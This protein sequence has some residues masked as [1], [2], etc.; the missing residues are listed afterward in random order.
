MTHLMSS[1]ALAVVT[2]PGATDQ[3]RAIAQQ[4]LSTMPSAEGT[5]EP[6]PVVSGDKPVGDP[7]EMPACLDRIGDLTPEQIDQQRLDLLA[8]RKRQSGIKSPGDKLKNPRKR[9]KSTGLGQSPLEQMKSGAALKSDRKGGGGKG[10][11]KPA[12]PKKPTPAKTSTKPEAP[13][14]SKAKTSDAKPEVAASTAAGPRAGSKTAIIAELLQ[15]S[16]GCT[17]ADVLEATGWPTVS[18]PQQAKAAGLKLR[19]DKVK[20]ENTRYFGTPK[21]A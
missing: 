17:T 11:T 10:S 21:A 3:A 6:S 20:G 19:K 14:K 9:T 4:T 2:D 12:T 1:T 18:M 15:R 8:K 7:M 5:P 16:N 13:A